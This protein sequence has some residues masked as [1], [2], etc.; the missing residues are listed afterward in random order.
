MNPLLDR[1]ATLDAARLVAISA[2]LLVL[3]LDAA[4]AVSAFSAPF[5]PG[6]LVAAAAAGAIALIALLY[7]G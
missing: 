7:K 6:Q 4:W 5:V 3:L 2:A 1:L